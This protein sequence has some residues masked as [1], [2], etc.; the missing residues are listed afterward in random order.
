MTLVP[1]PTIPVF[2]SRTVRE[3]DL[4][5]YIAPWLEPLA[6][7]LGCHTLLPCYFG[8][9]TVTGQEHIPATGPVILAPTHRS[10]WDSLVVPRAAGLSVTGRHLNFMVTQDEMKGLQGWVIRRLGGFPVDTKKPGSASIRCTLN[11]LREGQMLVIFPEGDIY[12]D[13]TVHPLKLGLARLAL[14]AASESDLNVRILP[15]GLNYAHPDVPRGT[16]V[17]VAIAPPLETNAYLDMAPR[18][19]AVSLTQD[20]QRQLEILTGVR[21]R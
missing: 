15:I 8:P 11:I 19:A 10:R 21:S 2:R 3:T 5:P 1:L 14:Q 12:K 9:I 16:P 18:R 17:Q 6:Y 4:K 13:G 7:G 20:L